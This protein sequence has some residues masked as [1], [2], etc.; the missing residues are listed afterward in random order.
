MTVIQYLKNVIPGTGPRAGQ[1]V[2]RLAD[3]AC[4]APGNQ[5]YSPVTFGP[6]SLLKDVSGGGTAREV[7]RV[8]GAR[9]GSK[10]I[11]SGQALPGFND[12]FEGAAP[13]LGAYELNQP[14]PHYGPRPPAK[15]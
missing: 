2:T 12:G 5:W 9:A 11:D 10:A 13:D 15:P 6:S 3:W 4:L 1:E 7:L 8:M 14:L